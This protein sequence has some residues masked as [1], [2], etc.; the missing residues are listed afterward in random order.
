M[1]VLN[2]SQG[3]E[4]GG[5]GALMRRVALEGEDKM[6]TAGRLRLQTPSYVREGIKMI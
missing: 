5:N 3:P 4:A 6:T 1:G 2:R